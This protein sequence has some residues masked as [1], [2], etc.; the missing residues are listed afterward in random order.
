MSFIPNTIP[1]GITAQR[2]KVARGTYDFAVDGG[3]I[4]TIALMGQTGIPSGATILGGWLEVTTIA[5]S[6]GA[7]T[8]A[9]QVEGAGDLVAAIAFSAEPWLTAG[10]KSV[11][12]AFTGATSIRT[13]AARDISVVIAAAA[14]TGGKFDVVLLYLDPLA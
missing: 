13:T 7:A 8:I 9:L 4:G 12:P 5:A 2:I 11:I 3:A 6:G 14:L 1:E 10:R